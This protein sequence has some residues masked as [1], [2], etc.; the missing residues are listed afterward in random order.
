VFPPQAH[1]GD[2]EAAPFQGPQKRRHRPQH[3]RRT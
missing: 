2:G 1:Q 3:L